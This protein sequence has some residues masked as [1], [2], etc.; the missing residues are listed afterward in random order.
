MAVSIVVCGAKEKLARILLFVLHHFTNAR[1]V[2]AIH[3]GN[4]RKRY[5]SVSIMYGMFTFAL[6]ETVA[7][8]GNFSV[9]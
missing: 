6:K 3:P 5:F 9:G 8:P 7:Y 1:F 2:L 4:F